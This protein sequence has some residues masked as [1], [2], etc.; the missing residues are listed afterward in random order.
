MIKINE[1][2]SYIPASD[3]PLSADIG[4]INDGGTLWLYDVGG[5]EAK[6]SALDGIY[7]VVISHFHNDHTGNI[8]KINISELYGSKETFK[9]THFGN[10]VSDEFVSGSVRVFSIPSSHCKGCLGM[11][12]DET[13]AFVGD[14]LYC[15]HKNGK[16]TYNAQILKDEIDCLKNIKAQFL[17]VSHYDGFVRRKEDVIAELE[18]VYEKRVGNCAEIII[19]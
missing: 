10:V 11:E 16:R 12:I 3:G 2:I 4:I 13:F 6:I 15:R 7:N 14:A 18:A 17:L 5:D 8:G 9:H 19:E 1:K